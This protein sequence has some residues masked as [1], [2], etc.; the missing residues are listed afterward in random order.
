MGRVD[1]RS[2]VLC[3]RADEDQ[4]GVRG[5]V[6]EADARRWQGF[7]GSFRVD[8]LVR[9]H[10]ADDFLQ[11]FRGDASSA[12][13]D[14]V[15]EMLVAEDADYGRL[16]AQVGGASVEDGV[17]AAVEVVEDVLGGGGAGVAEGVGRRRGD[18]DAGLGDEGSGDGCAGMRTPTSG[19]PAVTMSG[20]PGAR[21]TRSVRGPGQK[22]SMSVRA[23]RE[24]GPPV[25]SSMAGESMW[26]MRGSQWGRCLAMK[27][28]S[29][30]AGS[31]ALAPRP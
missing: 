28:F 5:V 12:V 26:Q 23:A 15:V 27:T 10:A 22:R 11:H 24:P 29:T 3:L 8:E 25:S 21:G 19:R 6:A 2:A 16:D 4:A 20:M 17:D 18:G 30:A 14:D 13:E 31:S 1:A 9:E 7:D